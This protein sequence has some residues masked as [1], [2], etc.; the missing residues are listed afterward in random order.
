M[1]VNC[2]TFYLSYY[3]PLTDLFNFEKNDFI[4][5]LISLDLHLKI[6]KQNYSYEKLR[7]GIH[8]KSR[9]V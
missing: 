7:D 1:Y 2:L 8:F 3:I 9:F 5:Y 4:I 6:F